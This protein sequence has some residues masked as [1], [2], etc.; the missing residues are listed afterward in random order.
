MAN[1]MDIGFMTNS[2]RHFFKSAY[3][4]FFVFINLKSASYLFGEGGG[5]YL[6]P[7]THCFSST[8]L[9]FQSTLI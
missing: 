2:E 7:A 5:V 8:E 6:Q 1:E 4:Y 9:E 3:N